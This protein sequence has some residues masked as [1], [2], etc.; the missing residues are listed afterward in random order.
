MTLSHRKGSDYGLCITETLPV[1]D[2]RWQSE[3]SRHSSFKWFLMC[4]QS[5]TQKQNV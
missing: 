4:N 2:S 1:V 3:H 5:E